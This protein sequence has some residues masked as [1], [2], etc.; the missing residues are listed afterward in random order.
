MKLHIIY[1]DEQVIVCYKKAGVPTQ[2]AKLGAS[3]M[4]SLLKNYLWSAHKY[5]IVFSKTAN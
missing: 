1:E 5:S 3:D 4:V 2:T